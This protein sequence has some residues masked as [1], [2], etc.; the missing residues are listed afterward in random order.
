MSHR[1]PIDLAERLQDELPIA[2][3]L[4]SLVDRRCGLA[5]VDEQNG[6]ATVGAGPLA[7]TEPNPQIARMIRETDRLARQFVER[8]LPVVVFLDHHDADRPEPPYPPHCIVGS[9]DEDLVPELA[10]LANC[11][12]ATLIGADCINDFV[13]SI[14]PE[15]G[16][17]R[18]VDW[19]N[20]NGIEDLVVVGICTDICVAEFV[21]SMLSARNHRMMPALRDVVVYEPGCATYDLP[22]ARALALGLPETAAHPQAVAHHLGLYTMASRGARLV[23]S[24]A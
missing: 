6:F 13:G 3:S 10:W 7:P 22:K 23:S 12:E 19:M 16:R 17:N 4:L 5:I 14:D 8:R 20:D 11:A 9:G 24:I 18:I 2:L 15:T 1:D 21:T